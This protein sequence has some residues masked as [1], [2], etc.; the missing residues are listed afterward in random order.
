MLLCVAAV[1]SA[2]AF[3]LAAEHV[4]LDA[5]GE[6]AWFSWAMR[7]PGVVPL[8]TRAAGDLSSGEAV[9]ICVLD[10]ALDPA[11]VRVMANYA[12]SRQCVIGAGRAPWPARL[13]RV[14]LGPGARV[15]VARR[16]G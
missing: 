5:H 15:R 7:S 3:R 9:W 11:W 13:S 14:E 6:R 8:L 10:P 4:T 12:L 16:T 2:R 1:T